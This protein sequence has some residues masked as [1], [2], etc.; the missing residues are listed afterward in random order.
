MASGPYWLAEPHDRLTARALEARR[1]RRGRRRDRRPLCRARARRGGPRVRALRGTG[2]RG[3]G[4]RSQRRLRAPR[5][6]GAVSRHGRLDRPRP[7]GQALAVDGTGLDVLA[8][9]AG[10]AFRRTGSL[11]LAADEGERSELG[12]TRRSS[13]T[14]SRPSGVRSS[15]AADRSLPGCDLP[16]ARRGAA[17]AGS[18]A[19]SRA[20]PKRGRDPRGAWIGAPGETGADVVVVATDGYPS[21]LLGGLEGL[22]VP[23]RA[24]RWWQ[25]GRSVSGGSRCRTTGAM[26]STT[27]T[28]RLTVGSWPAGSGT[29]RCRRSSPRTR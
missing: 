13:P 29:Y 20:R 28:R 5:R 2:D 23:T 3:R 1:R 22:I 4:E 10:D 11:R 6:P 7:C 27:G 14:A 25:P 21:G 26:A 9:L 12:R 15:C 8:A 19:G 18:S 16:P 17:A 24:A